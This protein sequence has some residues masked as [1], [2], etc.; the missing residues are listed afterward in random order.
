MVEDELD[1]T[2]PCPDITIIQAAIEDFT[3]LEFKERWVRTDL[4]AISLYYRDAL[5][6]WLSIQSG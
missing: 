3:D 5:R 1:F 2:P 4:R 6:R